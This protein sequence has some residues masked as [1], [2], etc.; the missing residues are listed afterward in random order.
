MEAEQGKYRF[1]SCTYKQ[2]GN[3]WNMHVFIS[4][5]SLCGIVFSVTLLLT[6]ILFLTGF[7]IL[8]FIEWLDS[9]KRKRKT[10]ALVHRKKK[11][12]LLPYV[13]SKD[14]ESRLQQLQTLAS[15]L[16]SLNLEFSDD[17]TYPPAMAPKSANKANLEKGGMQVSIDFRHLHQ[18]M[19]MIVQIN[20]D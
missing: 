14:P 9:S 3:I 20:L 13:P 2:D 18:K 8:Y 12:K 15:A 6:I 4:L 10:R 5:Y 1:Q 16:T 7:S 11:R 19:D 17:L